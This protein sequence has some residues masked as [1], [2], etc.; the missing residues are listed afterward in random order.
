[1][2][3]SAPSPNPCLG[4]GA[5]CAHFRVSFYWAE[6]EVYGLPAEFT[7]KVNDHFSCM[8]GTNG[9]E[10]HCVALQGEIGREVGCSIYELRTSPCRELQAGDEK[11]NRARAR[12]GLAALLPE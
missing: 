12:H 7:E 8:R 2:S 3:A 5:C 6:A 11:C 4:C 10:P 1:M 9:K